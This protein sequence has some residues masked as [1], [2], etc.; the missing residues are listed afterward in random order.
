LDVLGEE[1]EKKNNGLGQETIA[2]IGHNLLNGK[3]SNEI[4]EMAD[5]DRSFTRHREKPSALP[6]PSTFSNSHLST[7]SV[8]VMLVIKNFVRRQTSKKP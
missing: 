6:V 8:P 5:F 2:P 4:C 1:N 3:G 7:L